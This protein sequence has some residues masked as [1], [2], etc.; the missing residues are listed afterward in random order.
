ME[1]YKFSCCVMLISLEVWKFEGLHG[2]C[3]DD[4]FGSLEVYILRVTMI[5]LEVWKFGSLH[6]VRDGD[7][8]GS[9]EVY[10]FTRCVR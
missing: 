5:S 9:L 4:T 6:V 8:F 7:K 1:V 2:A 3:D 10:R